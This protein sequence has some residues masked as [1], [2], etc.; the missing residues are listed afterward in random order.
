[1]RKGTMGVLI[2]TTTSSFTRDAIDTA[3]QAQLERFS[4]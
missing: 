4:C 1:M 3:M 2:T